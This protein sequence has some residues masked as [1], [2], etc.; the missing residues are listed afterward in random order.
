MNTTSSKSQ[1]AS[2]TAKK[3]PTAPPKSDKNL[4]AAAKSDNGVADKASDSSKDL[5]AAAK[6]KESAPK[7]FKV[8]E[9]PDLV[10][11]PKQEK[12]RLAMEKALYVFRK[13]SKEGIARKKAFIEALGTVAADKEIDAM[14]KEA[15]H[16]NKDV[17]Q[18]GADVW[19]DAE[20]IR[21]SFIKAYC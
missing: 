13:A 16:F 15:V 10:L 4:A 5:A 14:I 9:N 18:P 8:A 2:T 20:D 11:S 1:S 7:G 6:K 12:I 19:T 3:Q 17:D 21:A